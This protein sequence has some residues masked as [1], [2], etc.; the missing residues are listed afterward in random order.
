MVLVARYLAENWAFYRCSKIRNRLVGLSRDST[1]SQTTSCDSPPFFVTCPNLLLEEQAIMHRRPHC[2]SVIAFSASSDLQVMSD[3]QVMSI[4]YEWKW[5]VIRDE[6]GYDYRLRVR[7]RLW[8][9]VMSN[10]TRLWVAPNRLWAAES[11]YE[12]PQ[13]RLWPSYPQVMTSLLQITTTPRPNSVSRIRHYSGCPYTFY[14]CFWIAVTR[15]WTIGRS[16]LERR[17]LVVTQK[18]R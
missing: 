9:Q 11:D 16:R 6:T 2:G 5:R 1:I 18:E 8:S 17:V 15:K 7:D 3:R 13:H 12:S 10:K 14:A 4:G